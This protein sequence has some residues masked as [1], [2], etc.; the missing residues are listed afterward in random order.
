MMEKHQKHTYSKQM[1]AGER[2]K[3]KREKESVNHIALVVSVTWSIECKNYCS[4]RS[5]CDAIFLTG[6]AVAIAI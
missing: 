2:K 5:L 3:G 4:C 6:A 1:N